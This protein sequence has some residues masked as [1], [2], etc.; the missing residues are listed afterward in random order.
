M[1]VCARMRAYVS[2]RMCGGGWVL[3]NFTNKHNYSFFFNVV[4]V[5]KLFLGCEL[6]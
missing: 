1:C 6:I 3:A 2:V 4:L 5:I